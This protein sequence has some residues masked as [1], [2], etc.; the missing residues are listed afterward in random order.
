MGACFVI[1]V[2]AAVTDFFDG[3][4]AR[5]LDQVSDF[6][7][8]VDPIVDKVLVVGAFCM[9]A[10]PDFRLTPTAMQGQFEQSLPGWLTGGMLTTVQPWM[11]VAILAREFI[12]SGVRGYSESQGKKFPAIPI[13]KFKMILQCVAIG[14]ILFCLAWTPKAA[15]SN[16]I[17]VVTVWLSV[18]V[19]VLSGVVY[20]YKARRLFSTDTLEK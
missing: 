8:M 15:W 6:G 17:K 9:L 20:L 18:L 5:K 2:V 13:G 1:Y 4:L 12:I 16:C 3:Y 19:T 10:G 14:S 11:V 7:R